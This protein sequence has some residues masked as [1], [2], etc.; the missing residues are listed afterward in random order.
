MPVQSSQENP[1]AA[2]EQPAK[3]PPRPTKAVVKKSKSNAPKDVQ[4]C[5]ELKQSQKRCLNAAGLA[6]DRLEILSM[7]DFKPLKSGQNQT[8]AGKLFD[9]R[10]LE[11][12]AD[13]EAVIDTISL[14]GDNQELAKCIMQYNS[15]L[16]ATEGDFTLLKLLLLL[17]KYAVHTARFIPFLTEY[18]PPD[19]LDLTFLG[20]NN[21]DIIKA[22]TSVDFTDAINDSHAT[23][24]L[25]QILL[26]LN[27]SNMGISPYNLSSRM[28][29]PGNGDPRKVIKR[30]DGSYGSL[31]NALLDIAFI[32]RD[33]TFSRE[34]TRLREDQEPDLEYKNLIEDMLGKSFITS[35]RKVNEN[36]LT[37]FIGTN[38]YSNLLAPQWDNQTSIDTNNV[39]VYLGAPEGSIISCFKHRPD[40]SKPRRVL[41]PETSEV[42]Y[43]RGY[44]NIQPI[45]DKAFEG[46]NVLDFSEYSSVIGDFVS[47]IEHADKFAKT[48]FRLLEEAEKTDGQAQSPPLVAEEQPLSMPSIAAVTLDVFNRRFAST[49]K[50]ALFTEFYDW[51]TPEHVSFTRALAWML[52]RDNRSLARKVVQGFLEDYEAGY[53]TAASMPEPIEGSAELDDDG[54]EIEGTEQMSAVSYVLPGTT[55][56]VNLS[57]KSARL[58]SRINRINTYYRD[59]VDYM[60]P[61]NV[62][63]SAKGD[64]LSFPEIRT[65]YSREDYEVPDYFGSTNHS[66]TNPD[67]R[68]INV[69]FMIQ[70]NVSWETGQVTSEKR[71]YLSSKIIA[72]EIIDAVL[73]VVRA[74][75]TPFTE[76]SP[77]EEGDPVFPY[78]PQIKG[79]YGDS[80]TRWG[81][82][83]A[84]YE[85]FSM[86]Y[87]VNTCSEWNKL[88]TR[89]SD[90]VTYFRKVKLINHIDRILETFEYFMKSYDFIQPKMETL[91][92]SKVPAKVHASTVVTQNWI[93]YTA[94][95]KF[96]PTEVRVDGWRADGDGNIGEHITALSDAISSLLES[97]FDNWDVDVRNIQNGLPLPTTVTV[98]KEGREGVAYAPSSPPTP[99]GSAYGPPP[100]PDGSPPSPPNPNAGETRLDTTGTEAYT[101]EV[102]PAQPALERWASLLETSK[103]ED[104]I[105]S[106]FYDFISQYGTRVKNYMDATLDLI[107]GESTPLGELV[108]TLKELGDAGTDVLQNLSVNQMALKQVTLE[109]E[110]ADAQ[111]GYLPKISILSPSE[112][113]AVTVLCNEPILSS[114]EGDTTRIIV[115]GIPIGSFDR[116]EIDS[117]FCLRL[118]YRDIEYPQ[119]VFKSK[120]FKFDK[121]LYVL[122]TDLDDANTTNV[123]SFLKIVESM[124]FSKIRVEVIESN[125]TTAAIQLDDDVEKVSQSDDNSSVYTNLAISEVLKI[126]YRIMLG[127]NF[128]E[129]TIQSTPEGLNLPISSTAATLAERL[130]G[131]IESL[132]SLSEG[133]GAN[134]EQL[135][136][137]ITPS[138]NDEF[139]TEISPI[140]SALLG[141]LKNAFQSR[142][143]SPE[144]LRSRTMS[145]KMFDRI[146]ALPVDPDE[147]HIVPPDQAQVGDVSTPQ[148]IFDF[149]LENGI[150]EEIKTGPDVIGY[151]LAPRKSAEGSMALGSITVAM[152]EV[153]DAAEELLQL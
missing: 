25:L 37:A 143:F 77:S 2:T 40:P 79:P 134:I 94:A 116:H 148:E 80:G 119:L 144:L 4:L 44:D 103:Q 17:Q 108:T 52:I 32:S 43:F 82:S 16:T 106:F 85:Q 121:D 70:E 120:S 65:S 124:K 11:R 55:T 99:P 95:I 71:H 89:S 92:T 24:I 20:D 153:D 139:V 27:C 46:K 67:L 64:G 26:M 142:L 8:S 15:V 93:P 81:F 97:N 152:T 28:M 146:Y 132:S 61:S 86:N 109:E 130:Q 131:Q 96:V 126:Y 29:D 122:P 69:I 147:F 35:P 117:E 112:R 150:I 87:W 41:L 138:Q 49:L 98:F 133:L 125:D 14:H 62:L 129:V 88:F 140:D 34:M 118:S 107:E 100:P 50:N 91:T 136:T 149:Y 47:S 6:D 84:G 75:I 113:E 23:G 56:Q 76:V 135:V 66:E 38:A 54:N 22:A 102:P 105:L 78:I 104:V 141:D 31:E 90:E 60:S 53:L 48:G 10:L 18:E 110:A 58:V 127:I 114:P 83:G 51:L 1:P 21:L 7:L 3:S 33:L 115:T 111:N 19:N 13:L 5:T 74:T 39:D 42:R 137:G 68:L 9:L 73:E 36:P 72:A 59:D 101:P 145:A 128:S 123:S 63:S 30:L 12:D 151:K 57:G 45:V